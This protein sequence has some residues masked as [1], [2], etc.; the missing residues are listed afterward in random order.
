M[1]SSFLWCDLRMIYFNCIVGVCY[2]IAM[3]PQNYG[4]VLLAGIGT[5]EASLHSVGEALELAT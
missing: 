2:V 3:S 1:K 4:P 5:I